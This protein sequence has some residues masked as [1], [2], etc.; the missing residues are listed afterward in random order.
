MPRLYVDMIF[1]GKSLPSVGIP[2]CTRDKEQDLSRNA[3]HLF[4]GQ[5]PV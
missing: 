2:R 5:L 3:R 4:R 1:A